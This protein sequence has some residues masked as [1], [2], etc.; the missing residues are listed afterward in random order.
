METIT[1][2]RAIKY[3][4]FPTE[5]QKA[6]LS[7]TFGC[8][9]FVYNAALNIQQGLYEAGM[10]AMSTFDLNNYCNRALKEEF[11][12]L[13]DVDKFALS[14]SLMHLQ[15]ARENFFARRADYPR[16]KSKKGSQSYTTNY[17]N[18]N[19]ALELP[20]GKSK[21]GRIKLPKLK[22][23]DACIYRKPGEDWAIKQVT[24]SLD[25]RGKFF[26]SVLFACPIE[27]PEPAVPTIER[28]LGLDYSSPHFYVDSN[29]QS[30]D[31]LHA[32]R[33]MQE[34]LAKEQR[35]LSHMQKG[36]RNYDNQKNRIAR[37]HEKAANQRKDFCHKLSRKIANSYDVVCV[38]DLDLR[39]M[40]QTLRF[41]KATS[42]NGFGMFRAFL[43]YKLEQDGKYFVVIDKWYPSTKTCRHCGEKNAA[44][45]LGEFL[46]IC[47]HCGSV[48]DRDLNAAQNI[49]DEGFRILTE[50][51]SA[52]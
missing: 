33:K 14:N 6:L 2:N 11:P 31:P 10:S 44:V 25:C 28:A 7:E 45:K 29:G 19:I 37:L 46:W 21:R 32:Y 3:Q 17:T 50:A 35:K 43:K 4:I 38:E 41:G 16:Y 9:R 22:W 20:C 51:L 47:P 26:V 42:D 30:P 12:F 34:R 40:S 36:S 8:V 24:V 48:I 52:T 1:I 23:V 27:R 18:G 39:N 5:T 15:K 49:R 13:R